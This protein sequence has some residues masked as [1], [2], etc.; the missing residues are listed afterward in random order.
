MMN[1]TIVGSKFL[2]IPTVDLIYKLFIVIIGPLL[3]REGFIPSISDCQ[4][5]RELEENTREYYRLTLC[6]SVRCTF[7]SRGLVPV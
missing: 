2:P 5:C 6:W 1:S 3:P 7:S 4:L